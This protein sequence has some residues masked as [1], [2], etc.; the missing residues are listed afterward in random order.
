MHHDLPDLG[1]V[2][3]AGIYGLRVRYARSGV[4]QGVPILLTSPWPESIYAFRDVLP[5]LGR[6]N[7]LIALDLPGFGISDS[8]P[9]VLSPDGMADFILR[10]A[11]YFGIT[12]MHAV[13]PDVGTSTFLL[14]AARKPELFESLVVGGGAASTDLVGGPL[15]DLIASE[16]GA[17]AEID[18]AQI[19]AGNVLQLARVE[20]PPSVLEDYQRASAGPRF[21][22]ATDFVRAYPRD[23]PRLERVLAEIETPTLILAGRDDP[24]VPPQN[25]QFLAARLPRSRYV[26]LDAGHLTWEDIPEV[27]AAQ[28][29]RWLAGDYRVV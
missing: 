20:P 10:A 2:E 25:G 28:I 24:V 3:F 5:V 8:R 19:G 6:G 18:G 16:S 17:F 14:A 4:S 29:E 23:L 21:D 1:A 22:R 9:E 27:Y 15:K 13:G 7:P 11:A 26:E 12:R